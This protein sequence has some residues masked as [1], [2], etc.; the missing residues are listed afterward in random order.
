MHEGFPVLGFWLTATLVTIGL[1]AMDHILRLFRSRL[2]LNESE[3][4]EVE[5]SDTVKERL[6]VFKFFLVGKVFTR[7][8]VRPNIVKGVIKDLWRRWRWK[9]WLLGT[10]G[11][12]FLLTQRTI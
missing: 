7:K 6:R 3:E 9:P 12:C 11:S 2:R 1:T 4:V 10:T 5:I 8:V